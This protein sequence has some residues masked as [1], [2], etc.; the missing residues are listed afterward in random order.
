MPNMGQ[1]HVDP[2]QMQMNRAPNMVERPMQMPY[3]NDQNRVIEKD[4]NRLNPFEL[5]K[6]DE[7]EDEESPNKEKNETLDERVRRIL[8][9]SR[10]IRWIC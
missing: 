9:A 5:I 3:P 1:Q 7:H 10:N 2:Y 6:E 4:S 8:D